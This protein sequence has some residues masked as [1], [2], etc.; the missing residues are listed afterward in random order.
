MTTTE[1]TRTWVTRIAFAV[2][3]I[4]IGLASLLAA[5]IFTISRDFA[6]ALVVAGLGVGGVSVASVSSAMAVR[7]ER[8]AMQRESAP[9]R[10]A[11]QD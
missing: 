9:N 6:I 2:I 10:K 8:R 3:A 7:A 11:R 4:L 5:P 1:D